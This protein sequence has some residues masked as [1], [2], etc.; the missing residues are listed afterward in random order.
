MNRDKSSVLRGTD[1]K[2]KDC[3]KLRGSALFADIGLNPGLVEY[4]VKLIRNV[5]RSSF[6]NEYILPLWGEAS[7]YLQNTMLG[8]SV[9]SSNHHH[10]SVLY[11]SDRIT[12][13]DCI[14]YF[15]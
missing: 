13:R 7:I 8:S 3:L 5:R 12:V 1:G 6:E 2:I 10:H 15:E 9:Q 14:Y 4:S 11:Q